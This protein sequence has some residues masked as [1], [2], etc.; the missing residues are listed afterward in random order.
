MSAPI[1]ILQQLTET[2][3]AEAI[4][5]ARATEVPTW[6]GE[7]TRDDEWPDAYFDKDTYRLRV[8]ERMVKS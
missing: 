8:I 7:P 5:L 3:E 2:I 4:K 6:G 1:S